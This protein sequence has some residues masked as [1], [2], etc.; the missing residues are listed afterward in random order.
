MLAHAAARFRNQTAAFSSMTG[1]AGRSS[2]GDRGKPLPNHHSD[3]EISETNQRNKAIS[4]SA[5]TRAMSDAQ[6][7]GWAFNRIP[8]VGYK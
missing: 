7:G 2:P 6:S 3:E 8:L 5:I 1:S 4:S